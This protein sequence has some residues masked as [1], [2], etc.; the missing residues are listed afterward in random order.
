MGSS[1]QKRKLLLARRR[2]KRLEEQRAA[3]REA[4]DNGL[5]NGSVLPVDTSKIQS[6]SVL[7]PIPDYYYD[8]PFECADCGAHQVWTAKQQKRWYEEQGGEIES[9]AI[10]CRD[11]RRKERERKAKAREIHREGM[12]KKGKSPTESIKSSWLPWRRK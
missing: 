11:C 9:T 4:F 6:R 2:E 8:K 7:P 5:E 3:K 12:A 10:R 1:R